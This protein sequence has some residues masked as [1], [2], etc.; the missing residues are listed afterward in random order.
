MSQVDDDKIVTPQKKKLASDLRKLHMSRNYT[1]FQPSHRKLD[2]SLRFEDLADTIHEQVTDSQDS[3]EQTLKTNFIE[4]R[5]KSIMRKS[6]RV[7][8]KD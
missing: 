6:K 3:E 8:Q 4:E 1:H 2:S 7:K 5:K